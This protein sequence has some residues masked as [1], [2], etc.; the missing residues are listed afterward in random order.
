MRTGRPF[1]FQSGWPLAEACG[2]DIVLVI[3]GSVVI[4][5]LMG[6]RSAPLDIGRLLVKRIR[7]IGSTLRSRSNADKAILI[8]QLR[9]KVWPGLADGSLKPVI[10]RVY[11]IQ[12]A[13][14]ACAEVASNATIGKVV[15]SVTEM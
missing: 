4:I 7:V 2:L 11:P 6:G 10:H 1:P 5:G 13:D 3:D 8:A 12:Q 15:L 9:E 14:A